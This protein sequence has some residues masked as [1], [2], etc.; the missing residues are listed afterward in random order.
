MSVSATGTYPD[1]LATGVPIDSPV[2]ALFN[3]E[4]DQ[5]TINE[6]T[7]FVVEDDE[8]FTPIDGTVSYVYGADAA[9][10][11]PLEALPSSTN[12]KAFLRGRISDDETEGVIK[13]ANGDYLMG[14]VEWTFVTGTAT[15]ADPDDLPSGVPDSLIYASGTPTTTVDSS[16]ETGNIYVTST[17]PEGYSYDNPVASGSNLIYIYL[18]DSMEFEG[19]YSSTESSLPSGAYSDP[20][21]WL[22]GAITVSSYPALGLQDVPSSEPEYTVEY[23]SSLD[24]ITITPTGVATQFLGSYGPYV[25]GALVSSRVDATGNLEVNNDYV[26]TLDSTKFK[27]LTSGFM[28]AD[29]EF[30]FTTELIPF[31]STVELIRL[32]IGPFITG[33]PDNT[34]A[35]LIHS[36]S[37]NAQIWGATAWT[38]VPSYVRQY[39]TC[40][41]SL[42]LVNAQLFGYSAGGGGLKRLGDL[43]IQRSSN[44]VFSIEPLRKELIDCVRYTEGMIESGGSS[45]TNAYTVKAEFAP[46]FP[47]YADTWKRLDRI[48]PINENLRS[49]ANVVAAGTLRTRPFIRRRN[50]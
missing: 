29:Y 21:G 4:M 48:D 9:T 30:V 25:G 33:V 34:V 15:G 13:A 46:M 49:P 38:T 10:F 44:A 5:E 37:I 17:T 39:V 14:V 11:S 36:N 19:T 24:L 16:A 22:E 43:T 47:G 6:Y 42:D 31:Y 7:F 12:L 3:Q 27:G 23:D 40:K 50:I 18:S 2:I 20:T 45:S 35:K 8:Y 26:V 28:S 32:K 1:H 41:T